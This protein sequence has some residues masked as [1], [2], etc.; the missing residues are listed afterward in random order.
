MPRFVLTALVLMA[1]TA[2]PERAAAQTMPLNDFIAGAERIPR[3]PTAFFRS[4]YRR[5]KR[6]VE[7]GLSS[8]AT[9]QHRAKQAGQ[10]PQTCLPDS[11]T[12]DGEDILRRLRSIPEPRR[13]AMTVTDG[14][15][16]IVRRQYPC[17]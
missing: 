6:E 2:A 4:D 17:P 16:E 12:F 14:L 8:I 11:F 3:N 7:A 5:L 9:A 13:R 1:L 10:T 15:R